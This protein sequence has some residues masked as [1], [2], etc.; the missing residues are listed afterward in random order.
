MKT[1]PCSYSPCYDYN[2]TLMA[3]NREKATNTRGKGR[4]CDIMKVN[5][6]L[7]QQIK[8]KQGTKFIV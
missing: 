3:V 7:Y 8:G 6:C 4:H 5:T 2:S 1:K